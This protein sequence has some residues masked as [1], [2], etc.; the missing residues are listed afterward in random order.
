MGPIFK[1]QAVKKASVTIYQS[2]LRHI[3]KNRRS[4]LQRSGSLKSLVTVSVVN[5]QIWNLYSY[6]RQ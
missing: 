5:F 6:L 1:G 3:P 2:K 4:H